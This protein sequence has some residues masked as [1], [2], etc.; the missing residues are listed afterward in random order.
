M[1]NNN[2]ALKVQISRGE[3]KRNYIQWSPVT[4]VGSGFDYVPFFYIC[5][6]FN[7][8]LTSDIIKGFEYQHEQ[9]RFVR[10]IILRNISRV[11]AVY[12]TSHIVAGGGGPPHCLWPCRR[13]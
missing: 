8:C 13:V 9:F 2:V 10:F 12:F 1:G 11:L 3:K 6:Y 4:A 7:S 5:Y